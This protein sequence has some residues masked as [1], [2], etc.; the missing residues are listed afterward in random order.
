MRGIYY[1]QKTFIILFFLMLLQA[2][3]NSFAAEPLVVISDGEYVMGTGETM[4]V[5]E[6]KAKRA[7]IQKAAEQAGAFVKS[8]T[9]VKNLALESDVIEVI[10]N[11][12]MKVEVID[13]KKSIV[14]DIDAI[15]FNVKI[16]A[17]MTE[18]EIEKNLKKT[19]Q[20]QSIVDAYNRLKADF[21]RQN[22]EMELLKK[23][24][25]L[26]TGEDKQK[27]AR[28][29]SDEERKY[30]ANLWVERAQSLFADDEEK[31]KAYKKALELNPELPSAYVGIAKVLE[32]K[33]LGMPED[34]KERKNKLENLKEAVEYLNRAISLD[35]SYAE[36]YRLRAEILYKIKW[37]ENSKENEK[38]YDARILKDIGRA[39]ALN[40]P[41][42]GRLHYLRASVYLEDLRNAEIEQ[43]KKDDYKPEIIE[44]YF[45]KAINE[46]DIAGNLCKKEDFACLAEYYRRKAG[47]YVLLINYYIN[48]GDLA[49]EKEFVLAKENFLKKAK[50]VEE[51]AKQKDL[52]SEGA[53]LEFFYQTEFGKIVYELEEGWREKVTGISFR[54]IEGKSQEE[55]KKISDKII[56]RIRNKISSGKASAEEYIYMSYIEEN[57]K[58]R[59]NYFQKGIELF[60]KRKTVGM[61]GILLAHFYMFKARSEES[62]SAL[63]YLNKAKT[64]VDKN[65]FL[66]Q[67]ML[68]TD[69][70]NELTE[71]SVKLKSSRKDEQLN[72]FKH[73]GKL[74]K[75]PAE[76]FY[77]LS[78]ALEITYRKAEIYEKLDL[79][80]KA[81]E[82]YL[83][84]CKT[85]KD[86]NACKNAERLKK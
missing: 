61:D 20:D 16:K 26:S 48:R 75:E 45:N 49:K 59:E 25:A 56:S 65:L 79:P 66:V 22:K 83:Y 1:S 2:F 50:E 38:D 43:A 28:L 60:V 29:V 18:E 42:R 6:E 78:F 36:A 55:Q 7:A 84:L 72:I 76:S 81:R 27:I 37:L 68:S 5:S 15:K 34:D 32:F 44:E 19:M 70:F 4:E 39:L 71:L 46:I 58:I 62:D 21:E 31:L 17:V 23:Q 35:E 24:L 33:Y 67:K 85:F 14:G 74:K 8:Y 77:W 11:H 51:H 41:D 52:K 54:D 53:S 63:N 69:E 82:E 30:R 64:V 80:L 40:A 86:D 47:A 9:K 3:N 13:K 57:P 73:L 10:A 12:S